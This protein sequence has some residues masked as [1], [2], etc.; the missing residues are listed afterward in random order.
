MAACRQQ[1]QFRVGARPEAE[2]GKKIALAVRR[3]GVDLFS[4]AQQNPTVLYVK[5]Q[6]RIT[7]IA[8]SSSGSVAHSSSTQSG[9]AQSA[10]GNALMSARD[11]QS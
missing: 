10:T 4:L 7:S 5:P 1:T 6:A 11:M 9:A 2:A 3:S 8:L